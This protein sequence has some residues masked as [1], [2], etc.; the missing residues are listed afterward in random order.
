MKEPIWVLP[1]VAV[2]LH[3]RLLAEH[4]G[5]EGVRD[6]GALD[7]ALGRPRQ[8]FAYGKPD[9]FDLAAA[10]ASGIVRN[11]PFVDGNKRVGFVVA[12]VFLR[13]NGYRLVADEAEATIMTLGLAAGDVAEAVYADWLR[14]NVE[15]MKRGK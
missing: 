8:V 11:H 15:A 6:L 5:A 12:Y 13:R 14:R 3:G 1:A 7:A 2:A 10:Y 4:G 9:L